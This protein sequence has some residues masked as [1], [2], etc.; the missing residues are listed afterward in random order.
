MDGER[1]LEGWVP[2]LNGAVTLEQVIEMAF[3]YR[4]N[5]TVHRTD[6]TQVVGYVFNRD[7][8]A[9]EPFIQMFDEAGNGP[10][11]LLYREIANIHFTGKD[12]AFGKS[13]DAWVR[14]REKVRAKVQAGLP[15]EVA[16]REVDQE[17]AG[18]C[19]EEA[20]G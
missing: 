10:V 15:E 18:E 11:K 5:V 19:R 17:E 3:D 4:G 16:E 7:A 14:R 2:E 8:D 1:T 13:W 12:T 20:H 9:D 6:G